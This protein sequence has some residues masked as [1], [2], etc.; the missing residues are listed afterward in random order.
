ML[1]VLSSG[2]PNIAASLKNHADFVLVSSALSLIGR[3]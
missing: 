1:G 2:N 3:R